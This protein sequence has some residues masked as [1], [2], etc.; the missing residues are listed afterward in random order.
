MPMQAS[1]GNGNVWSNILD[2]V[3]ISGLTSNT[4][5]I[6]TGQSDAEDG[7]VIDVEGEETQQ[8]V[9]LSPVYNVFFGHA[10]LTPMKSSL[11]HNY[12]LY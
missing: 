3:N 10:V 6:N 11:N 12:N 7:P 2:R 9:T 5:V 8:P 4:Q 1:S